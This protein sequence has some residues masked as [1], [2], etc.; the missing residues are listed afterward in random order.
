MKK[1][2][3]QPLF[4]IASILLVQCSVFENEENNNNTSD[5]D[6]KDSNKARPNLLVIQTDEHNFRTLGC[7]RKVLSDEQAFIWGENSFVETP[8]IDYL[9]ANGSMFTKYYAATPV[10]SPSRG[11]FISGMYPHQNGVTKNNL[12]LNDGIVTYS[13]VLADAG[14]KTGFIGK[15]HLEGTGKPQWQP[16]RKFGFDDNKYMFNRGHWKQLGD[17]E[18]GPEVVS[19]NSAGATEDSYTT[20]FLTNKAIA[21]MDKNKAENFSLYLSLPD[22]HGPDNVREPY[23]RMYSDMTFEVPRN[24]N[25]DLENAPSWA[26]PQDMPK[27][28]HDQYFGM[29]KLIDDNVGKIID[30]LREKD[31]LENTII[32]FTSDHG[33]LRAEHGRHNKGN[34]LEASAKIPFIVTHLDRIRGQSIVKNAFNTTD[35]APT[36][37]SYMEQEVPAKMIGRNFS[38]LLRNSVHQENFRDF[39]VLR[40]SGIGNKG[41]WVAAINS[42]YKLVLSREDEPWLIDME[43][44]PDEL[45]NFIAKKENKE[46]VIDLA[47]RLKKY[48]IKQSDP[49]LSGT[50]MAEDLD[51][52]I[53]SNK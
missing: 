22:P 40:S 26:K 20:D 31:L 27:L 29:V 47:K 18:N 52:L 12:P 6:I 21:F 51:K 19:E 9:A 34:P 28:T 3:T 23:N 30:F 38:S 8:N 50:K 25:D 46:V 17:T 16:S 48:A 41:R 39:T 49:Y 35:F 24:F 2:L 44:D 11:T 53:S 4:L 14:Y 36:I 33:D 5:T 43:I 1:R 13:E 10:C 7:Y 15:W 32:V 45:I 42:R 37:L